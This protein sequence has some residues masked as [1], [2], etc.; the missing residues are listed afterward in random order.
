MAAVVVDSY[1][2]VK[3]DV[4]LQETDSDIF[5]DYY[6]SMI[7]G[8]K[9]LFHKWPSDLAKKL[10]TQLV[11]RAV[12][13]SNLVNALN[14][15]PK[16]AKSIVDTYFPNETIQYN[17]LHDPLDKML[18]KR[19]TSTL[20][21]NQISNLLKSDTTEIQ[22]KGLESDIAN[23]AAK[24]DSFR[25]EVLEL[26]KSAVAAKESPVTKTPLTSSL[27][28]APP[29]RHLVLPASS[30]DSISAPSTEPVQVYHAPVYYSAVRNAEVIRHPLPAPEPPPRA[31]GTS[32]DQSRNNPSDGRNILGLVDLVFCDRER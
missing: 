29:A 20:G 18:L 15:S 11:M 10:E 1:T 26:L 14:I 8:F 19:A 4:E 32:P 31:L 12:T 25:Q 24:Q 30:S 17:R 16:T 27:A 23:I 22:I 7:N 21:H 9:A 28:H 13:E 3:E 2:K 5:N 6:C